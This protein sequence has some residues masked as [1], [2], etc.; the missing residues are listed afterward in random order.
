[1]LA[2]C[3]SQF[4]LD[5]HRR[6]LKLFI[7]TESTS[8]HEFASQFGLAI[9]LYA[10]NTLTLGETG[11]QASVYFNEQ[12]TDHWSPAEPAKKGVTPSRLGDTD[13]SN[14]DHL[15]GGVSVC[16]Q[17]TIVIFDPG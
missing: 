12:A 14:S 13:T 3:R 6:C 7:P 9:F 15:N 8:C 11:S 17:Y 16:L 4:L 1:M 10:R 2:N 5:R